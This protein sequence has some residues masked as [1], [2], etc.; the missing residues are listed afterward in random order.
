MSSTT[1]VQGEATPTVRPFGWRD[2]VGYMF[3]D[4]GNDFT[5]IMA[6]FYLNIFYIKG[7]G[8]PTGIVATM[9]FAAKLIDAFTDVGMGR[10]LDRGK[11]TAAGR[12]R[13]WIL[14]GAVP[15]AVASIGIYVMPWIFAPGDA[16]MGGKIAWMWVTYVLW[17]SITYTMINIP[18]GAMAS[19]ISSEPDDRAQLSVFR[20]VGATL[21]ALTIS[22][23]T[24]LFIF[25]GDELLLDNIPWIAITYGVLA[26][27]CYL[28]CYINVRER[29]KVPP[30]PK[31]ESLSLGQ[32]FASMFTN[33]AL[34]GMVLAA[35]ALLFASLFT[36]SVAAFLWV[37]YFGNGEMQSIAQFVQFSPALVLALFIVPL[38]KRFGKKEV[39]VVGVTICAVLNIAMYFMDL[40]G[41]P[42]V[43]IVLFA[44][45]G[46][47]LG[48][49][50]ILIWAFLTDVIDYQDVRTNERADGTVYAVYS[51]SRK[52]G[53]ALASS[54]G[55]AAIGWIGYNQA[56]DAV[57]TADVVNG[58]WMLNT[59]VPGI[60][61]AVCALLLAFVYPLGK[62]QVQENVAIL[63]AR[64]LD[65][66]VTDA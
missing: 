65:G 38:G 56:A 16:D 40:Q 50:N 24:P 23:V 44:I 29:V 18:Y 22:V 11:G 5:F 58:I 14:R 62:K 6:S 36:G 3:G 61:Y 49:F 39:G 26:V 30:K 8:I 32:L 59:L 64:G 45:A 48:S 35:I 41:S 63:K 57:Q 43:Y 20:S 55:A 31:E 46:I 51:W 42:W 33:R 53:Q 7:M 25:R 12:F 2:R 4:F 47:G 17:G 52:F 37:D 27:V 1:A 21:A 13:P 28:L 34:L 54:M 10:I 9:F 60:A 19:V 66:T 15:V